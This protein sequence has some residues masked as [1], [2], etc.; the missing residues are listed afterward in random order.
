MD[1]KQ[2]SDKAMLTAAE[3]AEAADVSVV[4]VRRLLAEGKEIKGEKV[5]RDWV[6]TRRAALEWLTKR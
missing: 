6:I 1:T 3:V 5:G 2:V 4:W